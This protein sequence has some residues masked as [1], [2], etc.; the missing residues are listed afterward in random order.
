MSVLHEP[1][2]PCAMLDRIDELE[3][4]RMKPEPVETVT[5]SRG[6]TPEEGAAYEEILAERFGPVET[7][8]STGS[9]KPPKRAHSMMIRLHAHDI[10]E[11]FDVLSEIVA[12]QRRD[13]AHSVVSS[14]G[15]DVEYVFDPIQTEG[16]YRDQLDQ[17]LANIR[18]SGR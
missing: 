1:T 8:T 9:P 10:D 11:L 16:R 3:R 2:G 5:A 17:Y 14:C 18:G 4:R 15:Y 6:L 12:E 13:G 7:V